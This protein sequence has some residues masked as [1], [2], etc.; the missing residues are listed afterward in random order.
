MGL[1]LGNVWNYRLIPSGGYERDSVEN[2]QSLPILGTCMDISGKLVKIGITRDTLRDSIFIW[3]GNGYYHHL[4]YRFAKYNPALGETWEAWNDCLLTLGTPVAVGDIDGDSLADTVIYRP[5]EATVE[6][7]DAVVGGMPG[8]I[9]V[10][11]SL[12]QKITLTSSMS[13]DSML[14]TEFR[15]YYYKPAF[16]IT[17]EILDS[18]TTRIF[19]GS[20][21]ND[22][23]TPVGMGKE[24]VSVGVSENVRSSPPTTES[25]FY[26][27]A[28]RRTEGK[29][30]L[31]KGR[32]VIW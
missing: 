14:V 19:Y 21:A 29:G 15:S 31:R 1:V 5:S 32:V 24:I 26:D 27:K 13:P 9:K 7:L 3:A 4:L 10:V 16:G 22:L 2:V 20:F 12:H 25:T 8:N 23:T 6:S 28:G 18:V 11:L 17:R 30:R